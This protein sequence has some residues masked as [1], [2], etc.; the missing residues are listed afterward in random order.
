MNKE[1]DNNRTKKVTNEQPVSLHP[2]PFEDALRD[3][4][5][6]APPKKLPDKKK[7]TKLKS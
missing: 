7:R 2:V 1:T 4:L 5:N 6:T 3:L